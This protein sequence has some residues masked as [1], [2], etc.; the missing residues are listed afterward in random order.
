M[1][2][3]L[4]KLVLSL[5][6]LVAVGIGCLRCR[7]N[8]SAG[9]KVQP[10]ASQAAASGETLGKSAERP[11]K[12][13][14]RDAAVSADDASLNIVR[15]PIAKRYLSF[16]VAGN[17]RLAGQSHGASIVNGAFAQAW[18]LTSRMDLTAEQQ[19]R[20]AEFLLAEDWLRWDSMDPE[21]SRNG[22]RKVYRKN[23]R[24]S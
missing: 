15:S 4:K 10:S 12:A 14:Q 22:P 9:D 20:L 23:S 5:I 18:I 1:N 6:I 19:D 2:S 3:N 16:M 24:R 21:K 17:G 13:S 7:D 11:T 8:S